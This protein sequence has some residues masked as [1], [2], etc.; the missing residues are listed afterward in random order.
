MMQQVRWGIIGCG[1]VVKKKSGKAFV[2]ADGSGVA[3]VCSRK[4]RFIE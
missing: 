1:N 2:L 3:A 4:Y